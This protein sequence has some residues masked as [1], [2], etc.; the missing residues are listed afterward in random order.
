MALPKID[1]PV[2]EIELP[3]SKKNIRFRPFLVKEQ[4]NLLM[5][6]ES[7]DTDTISNNIRQILNNCT[8]SNDVDIEGL[9]I[10]DIEYYFL[11]LRARSV[12][13]V[14]ETKY[15]CN[16]SAVKEDGTIKECGNTMD[17]NVNLLDIK[18]QKDESLSDLI[19][20]N[21]R[22]V[23]KM[24]FPPFSSIQKTVNLKNASDIA[25]EL[26]LDSIEII[27]DGEEA[28]Y[29]KEATREELQEFVESLNKAQFEKIEDFFNNSPRLNKNVEVKCTRCGFEHEIYFEGLESFFD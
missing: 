29:T 14:V 8:V 15:R 5:A 25:F 16:N 17:V 4:K 18:V 9:P 10:I 19:Q 20:I 6:L 2:Y 24:R 26:I 28:Y 12:G 23:L 21:D 11:N 7:D 13:E 3:L 22:I 27:F 1:T